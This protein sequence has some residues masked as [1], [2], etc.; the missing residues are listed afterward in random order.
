MT[1][2][3]KI[4]THDWPVKVEQTDRRGERDVVTETFEVAPHGER[5]VYLTSSRSIALSELPK[6]PAE[7]PAPA[8][9]G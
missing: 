2:T 4:I 7:P 6:P 3:V 1:T 5:T 9:A 8:T